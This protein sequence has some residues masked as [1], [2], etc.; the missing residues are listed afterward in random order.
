VTDAEIARQTVLVASLEKTARA[1]WDAIA[2]TDDG[3]EYQAAMGVVRQAGALRRSLEQ[4]IVARATKAQ[5]AAA[6]R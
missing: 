6:S 5:R 2:R 3:I 4:W 1:H